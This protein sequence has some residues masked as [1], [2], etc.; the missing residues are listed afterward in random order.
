MEVGRKNDGASLSSCSKISPGFQSRL[1]RGSLVCLQ[2]LKSML[3]TCYLRRFKL[4]PG[5]ELF[6]FKRCVSGLLEIT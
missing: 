6:H 5:T 2:L 3:G 1:G 4:Q